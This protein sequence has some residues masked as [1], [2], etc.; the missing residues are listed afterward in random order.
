MVKKIRELLRPIKKEFKWL[1]FYINALVKINII[2][3]SILLVGEPLHGNI[4]DAAIALAERKFLNDNF[5]KKIFAIPANFIGN[6]THMFKYLIKKQTPILFHGGGFIG[7]LWPNQLEDFKKTLK[8]FYSNKILLF[9]Q[10]CFF[11]NDDIGS[12]VKRELNSYFS[13]CEDLTICV[14]EKFSYD[15]LINQFSDIKVFL[16]P[17]MVT[18]LRADYLG[19]NNNSNKRDNLLCCIRNDKEK[20]VGENEEKLFVEKIKSNY[21]LDVAVYTDTVISQAINESDRYK[22]VSD[23]VNEFAKYKCVVTDRLHGMVF[24]AIAGTPCIVHKCN[25]YKI[26]GVYEWI[27]NNCYIVFSNKNSNVQDEFGKYIACSNNKY[28]NSKTNE[29]FEELARI[30]GNMYE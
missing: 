8:V 22:I 5:D 18:Y 1:C 3:Q 10:T 4:G 28:D 2:N 21:K 27:N 17:D 16:I 7:T 13:N 12:K 25:N 14:R 19:I 9:P 26:E 29:K 6:H 30:I 11:S 24:A 23:K 20:V 15:V